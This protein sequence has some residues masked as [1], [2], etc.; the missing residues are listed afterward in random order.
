MGFDSQFIINRKD[1]ILLHSKANISP[2]L[3][4]IKPYDISRI[5]QSALLSSVCDKIDWNVK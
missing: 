2:K 3:T 5:T 1:E 4:K